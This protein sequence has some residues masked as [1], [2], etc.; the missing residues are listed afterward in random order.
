MGGSGL[1]ELNSVL[2]ECTNVHS[3]AKKCAQMIKFISIP[4]H[5]KC[6]NKPKIII[7]E[8]KYFRQTEVVT[9][10]NR[11]STKCTTG[12]VGDLVVGGGGLRSAVG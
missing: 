2:L 8:N 1:T 6:C 9:A 12:W 3:S 7:F 10:H 4:V 11:D 5:N